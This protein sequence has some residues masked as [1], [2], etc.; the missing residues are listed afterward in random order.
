MIH[1]TQYTTTIRAYHNSPSATKGPAIKHRLTDGNDCNTTVNIT[2]VHTLSLYKKIPPTSPAII[3][4]F[5]LS[6]D[7]PKQ[8]TIKLRLKM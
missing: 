2:T 6:M 3:R 5:F 1:I 4:N 8:A 7:S